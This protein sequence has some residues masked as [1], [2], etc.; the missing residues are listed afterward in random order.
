ML[1][2]WQKECADLDCRLFT[3]VVDRRYWVGRKIIY[4]EQVTSVNSLKHDKR[5][6]NIGL[7]G[8]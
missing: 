7:E 4:Y 3:V 8:W 2:L 6:L 5:E 1:Q